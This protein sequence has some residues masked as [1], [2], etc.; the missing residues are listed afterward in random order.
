MFVLSFSAALNPQQPDIV[1]DA[2][3]STVKTAKKENS[4]I[5]K[6]VNNNIQRELKA[7]L[8]HACNG[9]DALAVIV[10]HQSTFEHHTKDDDVCLKQEIQS[11]QQL[12]AEKEKEIGKC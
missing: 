2:E 6:Q 1:S 7:R 10:Q 8:K 4:V 12:L 9:F 11:L 5:N 3:S